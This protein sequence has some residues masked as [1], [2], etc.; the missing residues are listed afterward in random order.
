MMVLVN[1]AWLV[2]GLYRIRV[3]SL[4]YVGLHAS[5]VML[6]SAGSYWLIDMTLRLKFIGI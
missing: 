6:C 3:A 2:N 4:V 5:L 1:F